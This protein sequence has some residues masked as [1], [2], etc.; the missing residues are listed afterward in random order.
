MNIRNRFSRRALDFHT[1]RKTTYATKILK[2]CQRMEKKVIATADY[3][4][5]ADYRYPEY[6]F[7]GLYYSL[8]S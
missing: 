3:I 1:I 4:K 5:Y 6:N 2:Y 8:F 7:I